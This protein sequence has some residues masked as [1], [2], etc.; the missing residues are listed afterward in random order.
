MRLLQIIDEIKTLK[1]QPTHKSTMDICRLL[2][3]NKRLFIEKI[4]SDNFNH[5]YTNFEKLSQASAKDYNTPG[6]I[7]DYEQAHSILSFYVDRI[8]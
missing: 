3:N 8:I 7:R 2:D 5:L 4:D 1:T 6:Y